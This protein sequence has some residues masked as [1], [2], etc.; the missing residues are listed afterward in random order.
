MTGRILDVHLK[1]RTDFG[2]AKGVDDVAWGSGKGTIRDLLA[3]LTLQ[4]YDGYLT[5]EYE[6]ESEVGDPMPAF[7]KSIAYVKSI[8][9]YDGYT[10]ILRRGRSGY[11]KYG[12]NH[13]GPGYFEVR[14][15]D[16]HPQGPGRHGPA[17]VPPRRSRT[18][19]SSA[20]SNARRRRPIPGSSSASPTCP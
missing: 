18:S 14:P 16:R 3:E 6:N 9:Y 10:Q 12:W 20:I 11:E 15:E 4:D 7:R 5:M 2:T 8:T 1:D 19:S 17:L 13:Y